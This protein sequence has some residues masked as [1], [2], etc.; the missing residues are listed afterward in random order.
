[1]KNQ[2]VQVLLDGV[3]DRLG[4]LEPI[5]EALIV[6]GSLQEDFE[7]AFAHIFKQ[8]TVTH[9]AISKGIYHI[10]MEHSG[11]QQGIGKSILDIIRAVSLALI[12]FFQRLGILLRR[13][14]IH[15]RLGRNSCYI[16]IALNTYGLKKIQSYN[17]E[18]K[19]VLRKKTGH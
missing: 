15:I 2:I 6:P 16:Q 4:Q 1:M 11:I 10:Y 12:R 7:A 3:K 8:P 13:D 19:M 14:G 9:T 18:Q 17:A 5:N